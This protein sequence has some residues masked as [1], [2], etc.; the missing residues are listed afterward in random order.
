MLIL[1]LDVGRNWKKWK[2]GTF[3]KCVI[4]NM[5]YLENVKDDD[6]NNR[7]R[8]EAAKLAHLLGSASLYLKFWTFIWTKFTK[9]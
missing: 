9:N 6:R 7:Y 8:G 4:G 2:Y 3:R 1:Y 5:E